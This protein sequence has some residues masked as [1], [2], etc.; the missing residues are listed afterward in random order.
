M[1]SRFSFSQQDLDECLAADHELRERLRGMRLFLTGGSGF[2]GRWLLESLLWANERFDLDISVVVLIR[3]P[4]R[5]C[6]Q[7]P[8]LTTSRALRLVQGDVLE[9][10]FPRGEFTHVVHLAASSDS[11]T[12]AADPLG[13]FTVIVD[14]TRRVL[15]FAR[16]SGVKRFLYVSSGAVYGTQ[17]PE[18]PRIQEDYCNLHDPVDSRSVNG[19]GKWEAEQLC[20]LYSTFGSLEIST[21]RAFAFVGPGL[22][23][24]KHF[25]VGNFIRDG[26]TGGPVKVIGDGS[27]HR[28]YLY[29][30]DLVWWLWK[31]LVDG[32][33]GRAYNVGGN[34]IVSIRE[35]AEK[36]ANCFSPS[37]SVAVAGCPESG[38][39]P[40]R[41]VPNIMRA[42]NELGLSVRIPLKEAL[43]R[44]ISWHADGKSVR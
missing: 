28:S 24:D 31:I 29:T 18:L 25:A 35:L 15:E 23:L 37:L 6:L 11:E 16:Q 42:V 17:P 19:T 38:K 21:A 8:L 22:P 32:A 34:E 40:E 41:Y 14:G 10:D 12:Q 44:T 39:K 3:N 7:A 30:S 33:P 5:F 43:L 9:F 20:S 2:F 4:T 27:P 26:L 13:L 1:S 36:V